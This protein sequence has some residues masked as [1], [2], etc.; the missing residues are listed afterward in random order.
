MRAWLMPRVAIYI[1]EILCLCLSMIN[2]P[3]LGALHFYAMRGNPQSQ[4]AKNDAFYSF[5]V[6][7]C[8]ESS[9]FNKSLDSRNDEVENSH[10]DK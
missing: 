2:T 8:H 9:L 3:S 1:F 7:D 6:M 10:N 4:I 5:L